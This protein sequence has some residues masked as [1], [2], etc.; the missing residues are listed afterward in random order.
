MGVTDYQ[1]RGCRLTRRRSLAHGNK[2]R[3]GN[4]RRYGDKRR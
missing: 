4:K 3:Y 1:N 2:C